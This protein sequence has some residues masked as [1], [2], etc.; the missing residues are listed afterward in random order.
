[1]PAVG[2]DATDGSNPSCEPAG[3]A[4]KVTVEK[5]FTSRR[6]WSQ[7]LDMAARAERMHREFF[8]PAG[9]SRRPAWEPP[10]DILEMPNE[11]L[12]LV[13]LP[14]VT[15]EQVQT[16][17]DGND[18]VIGGTRVLPREWR[19]SVIHRLELPQGRF[20]RRVRLPNGPYQDVRRSIADGCMVI[21]LGKA[22]GPHC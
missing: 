18:L 21:R 4:A 20:E 14:G 17:I 15:S 10:V 7:A 16:S 1:L 2:E 19:T 6:M 9:S 11:V 13:A 8:W 12:V 5:D 22:Q 3:S